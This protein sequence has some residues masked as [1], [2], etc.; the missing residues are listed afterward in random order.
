MGQ[1]FRQDL[2]GKG[3]EAQLILK[4]F[5]EAEVKANF[6]GIELCM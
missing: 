1:I 5:K 4:S 6:H 2:Y 3:E